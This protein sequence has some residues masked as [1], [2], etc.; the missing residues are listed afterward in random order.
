MKS[1]INTQD[2][3]LVSDLKKDDAV[4]FDRLFNKYGHPL[5]VYIDSI[6]KDE[7]EAE[8][9]VQDIFYKIWEKR[10]KLNPELSFKSYLFTI[11]LNTVKKLY[12]K[13][14]RE[15]KY[16]Q[17]LAVELNMNASS[18]RTIVEY[19]DLLSYVD[20]LIDK[21]PSARREIFILS[22][23]EG[24]TNSEI[25]ERLDLSEQTVKNQLVTAK[26]FLLSE[27]RKEGNGFHILFFLFFNM[28]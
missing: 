2:K 26:S 25:A 22:K 11:A 10:K 17:E 14:L 24:L 4:A 6:I 1:I 12:R 13:K 27:A 8:E 3:Q 21:L 16:R 18:D 9:A 7:F 28:I 23:K 19:Q 15:Q 5:F 20:T